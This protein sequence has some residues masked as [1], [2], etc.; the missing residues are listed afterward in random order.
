MYIIKVKIFYLSVF[1]HLLFYKQIPMYLI[2]MQMYMH[3]HMH[4]LCKLFFA[5]VVTTIGLQSYIHYL[6][7]IIIPNL[8]TKIIVIHYFLTT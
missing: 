4:I 7:S 8:V 2:N 3:K 5:L 1:V 6:D